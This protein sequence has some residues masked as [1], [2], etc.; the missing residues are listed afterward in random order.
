M[1]GTERRI[2]ERR[3]FRPSAPQPPFSPAA[4]SMPQGTTQRVSRTGPDARNGLSLARNDRRLRACHSGVNDPGL[5]LRFPPAA[6]PA[7]SALLLHNRFPVCPG[8]GCFLASG[9]LQ[10][11]RPARE[12]ALSA[13][14]PL[15]DC[16]IP[17]DQSLGGDRRLPARLPIRPI[18]VRSPQ[19]FYF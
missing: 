13:S 3:T 4:G 17:P 9:P 7:R 6:S 19:P 5:L 15:R 11:P 10:V 2:R 8:I 16:Y 18:S 12:T 1:H 14:A